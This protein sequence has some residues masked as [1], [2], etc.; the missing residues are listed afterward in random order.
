MCIQIFHSLNRCEAMVELARQENLLLFADDVYN[1]LHYD[2]AIIKPPSRLFTYDNQQGNVIS[3]GTFSKLLS[4]G[5]RTGWIEAAPKLVQLFHD[6][7]VIWS[8]GASNH[9]SSCLVAT[10]IKMGLV[11]QH[12]SNLKVQ[13]TESLNTMCDIIQKEAPF[14]K[15]ERPK[16][17]YFL[18]VKL[19]SE[20]DGKEVAKE[21]IEK[22]SIAVLPGGMCSP[23]GG[24]KN[25][26]RISFSHY[27]PDVLSEATKAVCVALNDVAKRCKASY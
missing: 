2:P 6:S 13:Y 18:W 26:I 27:K 12:I 19:P 14:A 20:M 9:Y 11:Q 7:G 8:A 17:G 15:V 5:I 1:L 10:A 21:C 16:G 3:N 24:C 22:H 25:Y 4:P 23:V